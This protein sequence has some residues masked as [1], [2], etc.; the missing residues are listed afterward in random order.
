MI[1]QGLADTANVPSQ[2][3]EFAAALQS[4]GVPHIAVYFPNTPHGFRLK[5]YLNDGPD[6]LPQIL[7]FLDDALNH[8]GQGIP[9]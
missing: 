4:A 2:S 5:P 3:I 6:L 9:R 8:G 7:Q 1:Y